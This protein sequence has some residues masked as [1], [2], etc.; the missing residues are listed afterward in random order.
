LQTYDPGQDVLRMWQARS[1]GYTSGPTTGAFNPDSRSLTWTYPSPSGKTSSH[2][3]TF[4]DRDTV[5][6]PLYHVDATS[7]IVRAGNMKFTPA[8]GPVTPPAPPTDPNR[9][10]EMKVLDR[11]VGEWRNEITV[12]NVATPDRPTVETWRV[13]AQPVLGGR[14]VEMT[15]TNEATG[16]RR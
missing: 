2:Q 4:V 1:T 13:K 8:R 10:D 5:A 16:G 9:P 3:F 14:F 12:T 7:N 11:L 6:L 15:E